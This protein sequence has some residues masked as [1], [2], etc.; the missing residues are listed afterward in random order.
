MTKFES[1]WSAFEATLSAIGV[2]LT[3]ADKELA[4]VGYIW[5]VNDRLRQEITETKKL[6]DFDPQLV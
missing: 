4:A 6:F 5:G 3:T 1:R 2:T